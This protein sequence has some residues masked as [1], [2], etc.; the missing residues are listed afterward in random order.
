M[1][2]IIKGRIVPAVVIASMV[3]WVLAWTLPLKWVGEFANDLRMCIAAAVIYVYLPLAFQ[4][5]RQ[6]SNLSA[7]QYL[8]LGIAL[9]WTSSGLLALLSFVA[10]T[11]FDARVSPYTSEI[12]AY[13]LFL[14]G[15]AG[16]LYIIA[17]SVSPLP[18]RTRWK[19]IAA[20]VAVTTV[21][22]TAIVAFS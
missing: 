6:S 5:A 13:L 12:A 2:A 14:S 20:A 21:L 8:V 16:M 17:P 9:S 3:F 18:T 4:A 11:F 7:Y 15:L 22:A 1:K 10:N 19:I